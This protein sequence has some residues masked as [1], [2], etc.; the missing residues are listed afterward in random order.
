MCCG[1]VTWYKSCQLLL[2]KIRCYTLR[3]GASAHAEMYVVEE[4]GVKPV[5]R[6]IAK[7]LM[8][9]HC[10]REVINDWSVCE[11]LPDS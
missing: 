6:R 7:P 10:L 3:A 8:R 9:R 5:S 1:L 2:D 4:W 11:L